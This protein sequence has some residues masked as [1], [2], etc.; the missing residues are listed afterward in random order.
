[1]SRLALATAALAVCHCGLVG[2][3]DEGDPSVHTFVDIALEN[4]DLV[5]VPQAGIW[6]YHDVP[7]KRWGTHTDLTLNL[8]LRSGPDLRMLVSFPPGFGDQR[9]APARW[10]ATP[11]AFY[12]WF[13]VAN[14]DA[15]QVFIAES[16]DVS[17]EVRHEKDGEYAI[18]DASNLVMSDA[19]GT[20]LTLATFSGAFRVGQDDLLNHFTPA[21][22]ADVETIAEGSGDGNTLVIDGKK[23]SEGSVG[24]TF[25]RVSGQNQMAFLASFLDVCGTKLGGVFG[26][27][28]LQTSREDVTGPTRLVVSYDNPSTPDGFDFW[29]TDEPTHYHVTHWPSGAGDYGAFEL[30]QPATLYFFDLSSGSLVIDYGRSKTLEAMVI[31]ADLDRDCR[32]A[33]CD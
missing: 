1:M 12:P 4:G 28:P 6:A 9:S 30:A 11:S 33:A 27:F 19:C 32:P 14:G 7:P 20:S 21:Q 2:H 15:S 16:G 29:G 8:N 17:L 26:N 22:L 31:T 3:V 13:R 5:E 18:V 10:T 23:Q 24:L 25:E